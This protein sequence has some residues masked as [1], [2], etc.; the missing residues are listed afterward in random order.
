MAWSG[1]ALAAVARQ[2]E[3]GVRRHL[4]AARAHLGLWHVG[5]K[6][7]AGS[8]GL[9]DYCRHVARNRVSPA[10]HRSRDPAEP[11]LIGQ[12]SNLFKHE[13]GSGKCRIKPRIGGNRSSQIM[14]RDHLISVADDT[15]AILLPLGL[16]HTEVAE[17]RCSDVFVRGLRSRLRPMRVFVART[18]DF[19]PLERRRLHQ[20]IR[21]HDPERLLG[22]GRDPLDHALHVHRLGEHHQTVQRGEVLISRVPVT[23]NVRAE[24][25]A[26]A[27]EAWP[28]RD[29]D[30]L[31]PERPSL[32]CRSG[33]AR[34]RG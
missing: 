4:A 10:I 24:P 1:Q 15:I 11:V 32:G 22:L 5:T 8:K 7:G 28:R 19:A 21:G 27:D 33:S 23:P 13:V 16:L 2:L 20:E 34:A 25:P 31:G 6:L 30:H 29:D 14:M 18:K 17:H 26:E 12:S 3:R 9:R